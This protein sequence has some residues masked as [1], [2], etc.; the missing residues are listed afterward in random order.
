MCYLLFLFGHRAHLCPGWPRE[1]VS[2]FAPARRERNGGR[3]GGAEGKEGD[4]REIE[5]GLVKEGWW[6]CR[7]IP[8]QVVSPTYLFL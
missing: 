4:R 7:M 3:G 1:D 8:Q 5:W 2:G 6:G